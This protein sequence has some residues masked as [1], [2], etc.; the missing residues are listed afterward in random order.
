M[1]DCA[2]QQL[3]SSAAFSGDQ[4]VGIAG[5]N[6]ERFLFQLDDLRADSHDFVEEEV[7]TVDD[8]RLLM[9]L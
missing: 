8:V 2:G 7:E 5:S 3:L 4:D 1:V 6:L 9:A